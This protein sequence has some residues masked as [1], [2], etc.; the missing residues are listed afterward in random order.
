MIKRGRRLRATSAIRDMIRETTLNTKD[1]IYPIFVVEG[2]NIKNEISSLPDNYHYSIDRL[3]EVIA[4]VEKANI[5]GVLLFGIPEHKDACG[6]EAYNDNGIVQQA[7]RKIKELNKELLVITDVCMCEY[8]SHGHCGIIH[9]SDVDNDET[10]EYLG[11]IAVSHAKAGADMVAPSDMMDGRIGFM[12]KAL[13]DNGF[14]K[15][16]IMS[17]S[18]KYCSAFYGPFREAAGS[19][20][21]FGNRKTYQMDP[22][23]RLEA[24]RETEKDIEEGCDIIMVKP[25][26]PY[27]D[28][29]RECKENFNMPLAAY[30]VSGEYAMVKAA[31]KQGLIDEERIIMEILTS[32]KRAG[33]DIIITYHA[34][35][36]AKILNR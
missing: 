4:E 3:H 24:L 2:E 18:A 27:L 36:A 5:A 10:L 9:E 19:A 35:E 26:L 32:I 11:K 33:A 23:N 14:K 20:P 34:L 17:Y 31:G 25:A 12:R 29:I 7:V 13:D 1:F 8:T 28:V 21:E 22:A 15:V 30:N 16:S 6:S